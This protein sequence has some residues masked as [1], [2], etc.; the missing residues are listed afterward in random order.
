MKR[1]IFPNFGNWIKVQN[2]ACLPSLPFAPAYS[3]KNKKVLWWHHSTT[4]TLI[5]HPVSTPPTPP[6]SFLKFLES[7]T[8]PISGNAGNVEELPAAPETV[9]GL[10]W[11]PVLLCL[12]TCSSHVRSSRSVCPS[13]ASDWLS[14][15]HLFSLLTGWKQKRVCPQYPGLHT[16][17]YV[18][19]GGKVHK[20]KDQKALEA[21]TQVTALLFCQTKKTKTMG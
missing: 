6:D 14:C 15:A 20:S 18:S 1:T 13:A 16:M 19:V 8:V 9:A 11:R 5:S 2:S 4:P 12:S 3:P 7:Y 21:F 17:M 10:R